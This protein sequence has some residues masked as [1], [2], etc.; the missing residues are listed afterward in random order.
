MEPKNLLENLSG[1]GEKLLHYNLDDTEKIFV[2]LKGTFG[3]GLVITNKRLY[4]LKW[5]WMSGNIIGGRCNGFSFHHI[6]SLEIKKNLITG[7]FEVLTPATQNTQKSYWGLREK[8]AIKSDNVITFQRK[9]FKLF[10]EATNIGREMIHKSTSTLINNGKN[11][12]DDL[13]KLADLRDNGIITEAEFN[14]KKK[15]ILG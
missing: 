3:E 9:K 6:V 10:Q 2:K 12:L 13:K 1:R 11:N 4:V 14:A 8:N 7:T 15:S 5:G